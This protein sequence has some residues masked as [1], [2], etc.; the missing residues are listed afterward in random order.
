MV[1]RVVTLNLLVGAQEEE[2]A[3]F[4]AFKPFF[5]DP[6]IRK[7]WHNYS[8]DRHVMRRMVSRLLPDWLH[9]QYCNTDRMLASALIL[10]SLF[11]GLLRERS[12]LAA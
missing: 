3:I 8:F 4:E 6:K 9:M 5:E 11:C 2:Q 1:V 10:T 7:V 12:Y